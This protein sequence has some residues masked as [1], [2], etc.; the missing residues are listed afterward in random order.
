MSSCPGTDLEDFLMWNFDLI[1]DG[2]SSANVSRQI[3]EALGTIHRRPE[4]TLEQFKPLVEIFEPYRSKIEDRL[5]D[6]SEEENGS[7]RD[8]GSYAFDF[9]PPDVFTKALFIIKE[10]LSSKFE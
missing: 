1:V 10:I 6:Y 9:I 8:Y 2:D 5:M 4:I 3:A 7:W